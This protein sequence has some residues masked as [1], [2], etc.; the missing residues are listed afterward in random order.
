VG[1]SLG[2]A[3]VVSDLANQLA[4]EGQRAIWFAVAGATTAVLAS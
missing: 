1:F 3:F 4:P 2:P